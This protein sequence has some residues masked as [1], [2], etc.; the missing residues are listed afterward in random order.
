MVKEFFSHVQ[1]FTDREIQTRGQLLD[2]PSGMEMAA[3]HQKMADE[4][5]VTGLYNFVDNQ[6]IKSKEDKIST[7]EAN[8][9]YGTGDDLVNFDEPQYPSI[10][11]RVR[12]NKIQAAQRNAIFQQDAFDN[13]L[14]TY[15]GMG[16]V[17]LGTAGALDP[18]LVLAI[19]TGV[20]GVA[21]GS[22]MTEAMTAGK[23]SNFVGAMEAMGKM[24][25]L[26]TAMQIADGVH[27]A[28]R[29]AAVGG[30]FESGFIRASIPVALEQLSTEP[31][32]YLN[33][34]ENGYDYDIL[35]AFGFGLAATGVVGTIGGI[36]SQGLMKSST[37]GLGGVFKTLGTEEAPAVIAAANFGF[38]DN[39]L[40]KGWVSES[41]YT[42][43]LAKAH[44]NLITG[45][46]LDLNFVKAA[47]RL[48]DTGR[49]TDDFFR[50]LNNGEYDNIFSASQKEEILQ[51]GHINDDL[52]QT[53]RFKRWATLGLDEADEFGRNADNLR[54][55]D[56][57]NLRDA[58]LPKIQARGN[59]VSTLLNSAS[60][61]LREVED[62]LL[63]LAEDISLRTGKS[64]QAGLAKLKS[65]TDEKQKLKVEINGFETELRKTQA[66][67]KVVMNSE[68]EAYFDAARSTK[69]V[70]EMSFKEFQAEIK[71]LEK[72]LKSKKYPDIKNFGKLAEET[73]SQ[74]ARLFYLANR[75]DIYNLGLKDIL[76][77]TDDL[78]LLDA[79]QKHTIKSQ[80]EE[81]DY[82][83]AA[84]I[85]K[86]EIADPDAPIIKKLDEIQAKKEQQ[87]EI[88]DVEGND[89]DIA[90]EDYKRLLSDEEIKEFDIEV[91]K[92]EEE[93]VNRED[94]M[95]EAIICRMR[96]GL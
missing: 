83:T 32:V 86:R 61:R 60:K 12:T 3:V 5:I 50:Q 16:V 47:M 54:L 43:L 91:K 6:I 14:A 21:A 87:L 40:A 46:P 88:R 84:D 7:Q 67:E 76:R 90:I 39:A 66:L 48:D 26:K 44:D 23:M 27:N 81:M 17:G 19:A 24:P 89:L 74:L 25:G 57:L 22:L 42:N 95:S 4:S 52:I 49:A 65:L 64:K 96:V 62:N 71:D 45:R 20:G 13:D 29:P 51:M 92:I 18:F 58:S 1:T 11:K 77:E 68:L 85:I 93:F 94:A 78:N 36:L 56:E 70:D 59:K 9:L 80:I 34:K 55:A 41:L 75:D 33:A 10:A 38:I 30:A 37:R 35:T 28:T 73:K 2:L 69:K 31:F 72:A 79:Y 63:L 8:E 15:A 53:T 82:Q